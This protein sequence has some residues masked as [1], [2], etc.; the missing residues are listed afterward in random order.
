MN[1]KIFNEPQLIGWREWVSLPDL[2]IARIKAK[3]D[4][5]ARTSTLHAFDV[6]PFKKKQNSWVRF[7]LHP[8]RG[9]DKT[10][11]CEYPI[12]DI[13]WV[14]DS[15][16]HREKRIVIATQVVLL[17]QSWEVEITLTNRDTM[18]F[19]MLL[20]RNALKQRFRVDPTASYLSKK[21]L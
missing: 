17:E 13:R 5:G 10:V 21:L 11:V 7:V 3:I 2:G 16:G 1:K 14:T 9:F 20:G 15:G 19:R 4:T 6:K 12:H 8:L 18:R